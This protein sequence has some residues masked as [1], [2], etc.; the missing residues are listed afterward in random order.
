MCTGRRRALRHPSH[1][2]RVVIDIAGVNDMR[3]FRAHFVVALI[4]LFTV[5]SRAAEAREDSWI[6]F[7]SRRSGENVVYRMRPDGRDLTPIFGG[8]LK[9]VPGLTDGQTLYR[10]PHWCRQSPDGKYFL[11][12]AGDILRP[13]DQTYFPRFMIYL[14]RLDDSQVRAIAPDGGEYFAWSPDSNRFA[15][16]KSWQLPSRSGGLVASPTQ[17]VILEID[18]ANERVVLERPFPQVW[19]VLDWSRSGDRLLLEHRTTID[20]SR[21]RCRL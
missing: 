12:W 20:M 7:L 19:R 17:I 3:M 11:D 15:Y 2:V 5:G 18:G 14:G 16:S 13:R 1:D 4:T 9:G 8:E 10:E 6:T 21:A